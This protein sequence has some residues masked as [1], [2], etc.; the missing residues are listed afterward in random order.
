MKHFH[1]PFW[2]K[3]G[4]FPRIWTLCYDPCLQNKNNLRKDNYVTY[5]TH[6]H[7]SFSVLLL[8][9]GIS[10]ESSADVYFVRQSFGLFSFRQKCILQLLQLDFRLWKR[11]SIFGKLIL[12][13]YHH[14][15]QDLHYINDCFQTFNKMFSFGQNDTGHLGLGG[16]PDIEVP[17]PQF[18]TELPSTSILDVQG[19]NSH[20]VLLSQCGKVFTCGSNENGQL[21][22][23]SLTQRRFGQVTS[24]APYTIRSISSGTNHVYAVDEW[25]KVFS[26]GSDSH[27]QLG[28]G[29]GAVSNEVLGTPK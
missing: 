12:L 8:A 5:F 1:K 15:S 21:G 13:I 27:N 11:K 25:G 19:G 7:R 16:I 24:L 22:H 17:S 3:I 4:H 2:R 28:H 6:T 10:N 26:W 9:S 29:Q 14:E 23:D 20:S 18:V